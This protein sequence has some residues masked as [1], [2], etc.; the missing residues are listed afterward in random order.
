MEFKL[1]DLATVGTGNQQGPTVTRLNVTVIAGTFSVELDFGVCTVCFPGAKRY[2]E[3]SVKP[4]GDP[5]YTTLSPRQ[6][7]L[8][9]PY[10]LKSANATAADSL[11]ALCINCV[12]SSQIASVNGSAVTGTIPASSVPAGNENYIQNT[13]TPQ[14]ASN[15]NISG[16]GV[17]GG[18]LGIGTSNPAGA[19]HVKGAS[20]VRILGDTSTLSGSEYVDFMASHPFSLDGSLD[21]G[22]MRIQ[23]QAATGNIDTLILAAP[24]GSSASE[25]MRVTSNGNVGIGTTSPAGSLHV[26]GASPVRILGDTSTLSGSEYVDFMARSSIFSSDLGGLRIQ[27][28]SG[29]GNIDTLILAAPSGGSA[30]EKMRVRGDGNVGIGTNN[31]FARPTVQGPGTDILSPALWVNNS[32]GD[33]GLVVF[34]NRTVAIGA[35]DGFSSTFHI[36]YN[37]PMLAACSSA[38][39][40]AP[41]IDSGLGPPETADVVSLVS[42]VSNPYDDEHAP[43]VVAK[44]TRPCDENLLGFIVNPQSG[45]DGKKLNEHYLPL[46]VYGYFPAKVTTENG[47]I[48]RGDPRENT[49]RETRVATLER[50]VRQ[51]MGQRQNEAPPIER[52]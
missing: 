27:R 17:A 11:S 20:P 35:L 32:N 5:A 40:Y 33:A 37:A 34:G 50:A 9:A 2:L 42:D 25:K 18:T 1:F 31:P 26:S 41:T 29:T 24:S 15:F 19:L 48:R 22:G 21:L 3:I 12:T 6:Q 39:E 30:S 44:S 38:A 16:N 52:E 13:T 51:L 36:C 46:A 49:A 47:M 43:F 4:A 28:Q 14:A 10:S 23:R 8:S 7:I 45:A